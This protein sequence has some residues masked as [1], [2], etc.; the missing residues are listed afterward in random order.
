[1]MHA[2]LWA[3]VVP[4]VLVFGCASTPMPADRL[5]SAEAG[6]RGAQEVG[7]DSVPQASLHL[8]MARDQVAQ[9]KNLSESGDNERATLV[10][11]RAETDAE[12][13]LALAR[14]NVARGEANAVLTQ[15][16][17]LRH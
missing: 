5:A 7:A 11:A 4:A 10:L 14:E 6:I 8:K 9:A 15:I 16:Q 12:L 17:S 13:A 2:R 1:M 3:A